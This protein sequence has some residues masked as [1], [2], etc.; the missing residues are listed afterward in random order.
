[1]PCR[2]HRLQASSPSPKSERIAPGRSSD[3]ACDLS[4][5]RGLAFLLALR[6]TLRL[7]HA[8]SA[9]SRFVG[10]SLSDHPT[11][12]LL[13]T[14]LVGPTIRLAIVISEVELG[15]VAL[16][17]IVRAMLIDTLHA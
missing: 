12:Q 2:S 6:V 3:S 14:L 17:A 8:H 11:K 9:R 16:K 5:S 7:R 10:E 1:M 4:S 15:H 13:C